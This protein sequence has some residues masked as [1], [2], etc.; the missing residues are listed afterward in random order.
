MD[1]K[2]QVMHHKLDKGRSPKVAMPIRT[3]SKAR[4][5]PELAHL[6]R[7]LAGGCEHEANGAIPPPDLGRIQT[8]LHHR[9]GKRSCLAASSLCTG[10]WAAEGQASNAT[11]RQVMKSQ[12]TSSTD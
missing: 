10:T 9:D 12:V 3:A 2:V 5:V 7:Q 8:M 4:S 1:G 11:D 6:L